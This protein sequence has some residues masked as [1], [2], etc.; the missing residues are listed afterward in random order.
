[1]KS[2][3]YNPTPLLAFTLPRLLVHPSYIALYSS[4]KYERYSKDGRAHYELPSHLHKRSAL[5]S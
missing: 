1:M 2:L 5:T 4:S 3:A